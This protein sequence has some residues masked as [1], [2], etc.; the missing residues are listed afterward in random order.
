MESK[1]FDKDVFDDLPPLLNKVTGMFNG[2]QKDIAL[3]SSLGVLSNAIPNVYVAYF[4]KKFYPHLFAM[5]IAPAGTGK[6]AM[7]FSYFLIKPIHSMLL[8]QSK[9][10]FDNCVQRKKTE[11]KKK[12]GIEL[13]AP[14]PHIVAKVMP[15]NISTSEMYS[16]I[17]SSST[18]VMM[19]EAEADTLSKMYNQDWSNSSD[20]LRKTF[21][22][23]TISIA[24]KTENLY[25][26]IEAPKLAIVVS[27]TPE[28][29]KP[30]LISKENGLFSRFLI[31]SFNEVATFKDG[32][33]KEINSC[34]PVF[35]AAG[36]EVFALYQKLTLDNVEIAFDLTLKQKK[37]FF[38]EFS[39][40]HTSY[41]KKQEDLLPNV[42]RHALV[43]L[44]ISMILTVIRNKDTIKKTDALVCSDV[45]FWNAM[46]IT[47]TLLENLKDNDFTLEDGQLSESDEE[48]LYSVGQVFTRKEFVEAGQKKGI[49]ERTIDDKLKQWRKRK[50]ITKLAQGRYKR[51]LN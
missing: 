35:E 32:F 26:E 28:Q 42:K 14:C 46:K 8:N 2:R 22:H 37:T 33:A 19:F 29:L 31:Y 6:A 40:I 21:Q 17:Q 10:E 11:R 44:R 50:L 3:L 12:N 5:I 47:K 20:V 30:L 43:M 34:A 48:L 45:D 13:L 24:R 38:K 41:E 9:I 23:E 36:K 1:R 7:L 16:F 27:G 49:P 39:E 15:A 51:I 4:G 25:L 18:G